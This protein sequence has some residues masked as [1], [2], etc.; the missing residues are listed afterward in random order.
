MN[1]IFELSRKLG[2]K[3][4]NI[5]LFEL[6]LTH[7]SYNADANTKHKDYERLEF[8][9]DAVLGFVSADVIYKLHP[10]M[11]EGNMTKLRSI[12][13]KS[14]TLADF[15]REIDLPK[16]IKVGHSINPDKVASSNKILEDIF[17]ALVG[18]LYLDQG[19]I[20]AANFVRTFIFAKAKS[21]SLDDLTDAKTKLQE[22]VQSETREPVKYVLVEEMGPAHDRT[23]KMNVVFNGIVL[24]T[25]IGKSKKIAEEAAAQDALSKRCF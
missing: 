25:G 14:D 11:N 23:F 13:V 19:I 18:A 20:A 8:M 21:L 7:P 17:E 22:Y 6:A 16:Y 2:I 10:D 12:L 4:S 3:I 1:S 9:G 5:S 24:G 15:A